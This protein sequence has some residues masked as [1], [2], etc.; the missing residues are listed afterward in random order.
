[1][2]RWLLFIWISL[3][4]LTGMGMTLSRHACC[5][6][7]DSTPTRSHASCGLCHQSEPSTP[8]ETCDSNTRYSVIAN[9]SANKCSVEGKETDCDDLGITA[10]ESKPH[11]LQKEI[12]QAIQWLPVAFILFKVPI[13][14]YTDENT[15]K[16]GLSD[17][18]PEPATPLFI[19]ICTFRI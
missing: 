11:T 9:P 14:Y 12:H 13:S 15:L 5:I 10:S 19:R 16:M 1:M 8:S 18:V 2:K 4:S 17:L 6:K 7:Q 3:Y